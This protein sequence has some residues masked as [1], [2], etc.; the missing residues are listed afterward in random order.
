MNLR[1]IKRHNFKTCWDEVEAMPDGLKIVESTKGAKIKNFYAPGK[2]VLF[3]VLEDGRIFKW[4]GNFPIPHNK[5]I[6]Y[7]TDLFGY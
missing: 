5:A 6:E 7:E 4:N 2:A 1:E 3:K